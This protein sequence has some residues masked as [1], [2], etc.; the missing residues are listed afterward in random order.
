M[1]DLFAWVDTKAPPWLN[2]LITAGTHTAI[3][4]V[5]GLVGWADRAAFAYIF[6]EAGPLVRIVGRG[7]LGKGWN[8]RQYQPN[9]A[10]RERGWT[11]FWVV[12]DSFAD[13]AG[14]VA[15][16]LLMGG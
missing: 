6:K 8:F 16:W 3:T 15:V 12:A 4:A 1:V 2:L 5:F 7:V 14:P 11:T 13:V 9:K 10:Q